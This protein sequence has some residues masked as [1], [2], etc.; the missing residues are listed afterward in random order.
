MLRLTIFLVLLVCPSW[1]A[2]ITYQVTNDAG[3]VVMSGKV[4]T[5]DATLAQLEVWRI[6]QIGKGESN[7]PASVSE[8]LKKVMVVFIHSVL[9]QVPT[10]ELKRRLEEYQNTQN[11]INELVRQAAH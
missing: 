8:L 1:A 6:E 7:V 2:E 11:A 5:N 10:P 9:D 3:A 4:E